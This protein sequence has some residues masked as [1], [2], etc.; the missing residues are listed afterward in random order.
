MSSDL[1]PV[2]LAA[3]FAAF[4]PSVERAWQASFL[5]A[6]PAS[7][8]VRLL[9]QARQ[10]TVAAGEIFYRGAYHEEM[11]M[12]AVVAEGRLRIY[13]Q[14]ETGRQVTMHY[15]H[16]G[17]VVGSPALLLAGAPNASEQTRRPWLLL[18]GDRVYGEALQDTVLLRLS[19]T[20]FLE[21]ARTDVS[22]AWA[23]AGDLGQRAMA[24]QQMLAD[25]L[26]LSVRARVARHLIEMAVAKD[27]LLVVSANHQ[28]IADAIGSVREV[29]S[30]T[31]VGLRQEG[32][33]ERRGNETVLVDPS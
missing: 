26:F 6:L 27:E 31:L 24:S 7:V 12:L 2:D 11:G 10:G 19:P 1:R 28:A 32:V 22:V 29:V 30:R 33:V 15:H 4:S 14:T 5:S 3:A 23:L 16:P 8:A 18:G 21:L 20:Q 9:A 17:A 13:L 25:D